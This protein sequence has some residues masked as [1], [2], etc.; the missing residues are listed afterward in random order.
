[1][2]QFLLLNFFC[3]LF[4]LFFFNSAFAQGDPLNWTE[5]I[6]VE[7]NDIFL[8]WKQPGV[9]GNNFRSYQKIYR[10][11]AD[12][13][14]LPT[15]SVLQIRPKHQD[16]LENLVDSK[17]IDAATG[18]FL[19]G[20]PY[21]YVVNIWYGTNGI[22]IMIPK[23]DTTYA[24]WNDSVRAHVNTQTSG[25]RAY[26][27]TGDFDADSLD[28]FV[29]A[30]VDNQDSVHFRY[31]DVDSDLQPTFI[32]D[33]A[34]TKL[35]SPYGF[36]FSRYFIET[37][38]FDGDG[39]D[40]LVLLTSSIGS[41]GENVIVHV[42]IYAF[43]GE[44]IVFKNEEVIYVPIPASSNITNFLM[45]ITSGDF[46]TDDP[47][48]KDELALV[49]V[50]QSENINFEFS[51]RVFAYLLTTSTDGQFFI[52]T[53]DPYTKDRAPTVN[54]TLSLSSGDLNNSGRD[55]FVF[56]TGEDIYV[57]AAFDDLHSEE[58][59]NDFISSGGADDYKQSYNYLKVRDVNWDNN[60]DIIIIKQMRSDNPTELMKG[61][62]IKVVSANEDLSQ[63]TN[64]ARFEGE[65]NAGNDN[66]IID[67]RRYAIAVGNFDGYDFSLGP[68][69]HSRL[70][71][72]VQP[73]VLLNTPPTHFDKF[74]NDI[75]D[76]NG[77]Y[78]GQNCGSFYS[79]YIVESQT[80]TEVTTEIHKD[81]AIAKGVKGEGEVSIEPFGVGV[82]LNLEG[83]F[84]HR[85]GKHWS[86][87]S[88]DITT[89][90]IKEAVT[91]SAYDDLIY[92][93]VIDYDVWEYPIIFGN[94]TIPRS[95]CL[96]IV[97]DN[98]TLEKTWAPSKSY[99]SFN[100]IPTH[101]VGNILSYTENISDNP[102]ISDSVTVYTQ[103]NYVIS[104]PPSSYQ[105]ELQWKDFL[106]NSAVTSKESGLDRGFTTA[107]YFQGDYGE[108]NV[109]THRTTV[110]NSVHL[111]TNMG[112]L[113]QSMNAEYIIKP[114]A[115]WGTNGGLTIDYAVEPVLG[116]GNETWWE[117]M[118][119]HQ[120]DPT[121]ILPW[122]F[123]PEKGFTANENRRFETR[124]ITFS[125]GINPGDTLKITV[126]VRNFS[127]DTT[128]TPVNVKFYLDDP[129]SGGTPII[130]VNGTNEVNTDG[131]IPARG[132]SEV[133]FKW[134]VPYPL[135]QYPSI[136][137]VLDKDNTIAEIHEDNNKGFNRVTSLV[138]TGIEDENNIIPEEYILYQSYP[139]PF[140][141]S[142]TIK[143][144]IPKGDIVS[145]RIYDILG[146]E[147]AVLT[148]EFKTAGTYSVD[149]N[150]SRFAS[151]VYFYQIR[152]GNFVET[153]KMVLLK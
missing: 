138:A 147:L 27:R 19:K 22:E 107:Y 64:I 29:V 73:L 110:S 82:G 52:S 69:T 59:V 74:G 1:M 62:L 144:S 65:E 93:S 9:L 120:P 31:Y 47:V 17:S 43:E 63:V 129:D 102:N 123:D 148:N 39:K 127:L 60:E 81:W 142:T 36:Q 83:H 124:D 89:F 90:K 42:K 75:F 136:Y 126:Q 87:D 91:D 114:Y 37:G 149:F 40:E 51:T 13:S 99:V 153:K 54:E 58:K 32:S 111:L 109:I 88:T 38:D 45:A 78:N 135:P 50:R 18:K 100:F 30:F 79:Q 141:P 41:S 49:V 68:P 118:Y 24:M 140:N 80:S 26:V 11:K 152:A 121:F 72:Q 48:V 116:I 53:G 133:K 14:W 130:G 3:S 96:T 33:F 95:A 4:F 131:P 132:R 103:S 94:D 57:M 12:S 10:Y 16:G 108:T 21:D 112:G 101:E 46:K 122:K 55:E 143:Y 134:V 117:I 44:L 119:G 151:G 146:S 84:I 85:W 2:K 71:G 20:V 34:D 23:F 113:S 7:S 137:A 145:I 92:K 97:P 104:Y 67:N 106:E 150:A 61:F 77:C 5:K 70:P 25:E 98:A 28:E 115:Y 35:V 8:L 66:D 86:N 76:L 128:Q 139:N 15:D 105:W 125:G 56:T 6:K